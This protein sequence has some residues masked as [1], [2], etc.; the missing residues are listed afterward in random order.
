QLALATSL[1]FEADYDGF[2]ENP[3]VSA[4]GAGT[5][6]FVLNPTRTEITYCVTYHGLTGPLT[7]GGE[8]LIGA[9]GTNGPA[10]RTIASAGQPASGTIHGSWK[11]TDSQPLTDALVDSIIAGKMYSNFFTAGHGAGEI[12]G[13][14]MLKGG[15]GFV[16]SLDSS[17]EIPPTLI[18]ASCTGSFILNE[19]HDQLTYALTYIGLPESTSAQGQIRVGSPGQTGN[20][21][22]TIV[23][24]GNASE[25][26]ISGTWTA[27]DMNEAFTP[28]LLGSLLAGNLY[29]D[30]HTAADSA[31]EI[32]GQINLA[33]GIGLSAQLAANQ[34]VPPTVVSKGSGTASVVVN[35]DRQSI[36]YSLTYLNLTGN[37]SEAGGHFHTGAKGVNGQLVRTIVPPNA[38]GA[39]SVNGVWQMSDSSAE[40]LTPDIVNS[41]VDEDV[42][43]NLHTG[44][45]IGGEI[46]GQV[47]YGSDVLTL[48]PSISL[49]PPEAC[50]LDQ[51]YPNPFNPTT[52]IDY[53]IPQAS[54]V[55]LKVFDVL[56]KLVETLVNEQ[57]PAGTYGVHFDASRFSSGVYFFKLQAGTFSSI[58]KM[59]FAK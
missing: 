43:I 59:V 2:Q 1:H 15:I 27:A 13:Q 7:S 42:Y 38:W 22:K 25:G 24:N 46:R 26:T 34:D 58:K 18:G 17:Q 35:P 4:A 52:T 39:G 44:A 10:V 48:V 9:I 6:V 23:S 51:N 55:T 40:Q 36:S 29:L 5:G 47:S 49:T 16:A 21:V 19:A 56:G 33:T 3:P 32:R 50:C 41:F 53:T 11:S 30:F 57:K 45:Y 12:R 54:F 20:V 8:I 31:S 37:I 14:L 28:E